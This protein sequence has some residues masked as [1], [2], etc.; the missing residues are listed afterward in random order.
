MVGPVNVD[1]PLPKL[2]YPFRTN[3][4]ILIVRSE[5]QTVL[6]EAVRLRRKPKTV[7]RLSLILLL[8]Q[9]AFQH[10]NRILYGV[11]EM[12]LYANNSKS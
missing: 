1:P 6:I 12:Y 4:L 2:S 7:C 11:G 10:S 3:I 8:P 5:A 9:P